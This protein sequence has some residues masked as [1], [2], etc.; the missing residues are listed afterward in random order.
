MGWFKR[1][2]KEEK[3]QEAR[4]QAAFEHEYKTKNIYGGT[5]FSMKDFYSILIP[6]EN[7]FASYEGAI[8]WNS[9]EKTVW[10]KNKMV[11]RGS[12]EADLVIV[13]LDKAGFKK[14]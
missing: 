10:A 2:T 4:D 5:L 7:V 14:L 8:S 11:E 12:S 1:K 3:D 13:K 6:S 9:V